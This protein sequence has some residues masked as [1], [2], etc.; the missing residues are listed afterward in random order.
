MSSKKATN[1]R[2]KSSNLQDQESFANR[3]SRL[4]KWAWE[5]LRRSPEYRSAYARWTLLPEG[6]KDRDRVIE[7][8]MAGA[9]DAFPVEWFDLG[10]EPIVGEI[11]GSW[12]KRQQSIRDGCSISLASEFDSRS[13]MLNDWL[14]P[15]LAVLP[16]PHAEN[17]FVIEIH[18][19]EARALERYEGFAKYGDVHTDDEDD[20][21]DG[22]FVTEP[23]KDF[24][25]STFHFSETPID[26]PIVESSPITKIFP[27]GF[28]EERRTSLNIYSDSPTQIALRFDLSLPINMQLVSAERQLYAARQEFKST[29]KAKLL[30]HFRSK[31]QQ[32]SWRQMLDLLDA[33]ETST[34]DAT[35]VESYLSKM[36]NGSDLIDK[37]DG[38]VLS[39]RRARLICKKEYK[40]LVM[41]AFESS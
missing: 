21:E 6:L 23:T 4:L 12:L 40:G 41:A 14:N 10:P 38:L 35:A 37:F 30:G 39:L 13:F 28:T 16:T 24:E 29:S 32:K 25:E 33:R 1:S 2:R 26:F 17:F 8:A 22:N 20:F 5:F 7:F 18:L 9:L 11:F 36:K 34:S 15:S 19:E 27:S 3:R 31:E